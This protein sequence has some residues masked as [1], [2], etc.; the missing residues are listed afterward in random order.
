M[1][2]IK[3]YVDEKLNNI[4]SCEQLVN[5]IR[6]SLIVVANGRNYKFILDDFDNV[7]SF[8]FFASKEKLDTFDTPK[9]YTPIAL[10]NT[11][12][13]NVAKYIYVLIDKK[14]FLVKEL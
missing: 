1:E 12:T 10:N 6:K 13:L 2:D 4:Y 11:I 5:K 14:T 9:Y 8:Q 7:K 3:K